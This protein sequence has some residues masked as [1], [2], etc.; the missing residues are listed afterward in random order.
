M[1]VR[2]AYAIGRERGEFESG[3]RRGSDSESEFMGFMCAEFP[4]KE[5]KWD[6]GEREQEK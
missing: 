2:G 3:K 4:R 1:T 5:C 6:S